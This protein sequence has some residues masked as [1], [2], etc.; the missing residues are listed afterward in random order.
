MRSLKHQ[1]RSDVPQRPLQPLYASAAGS[2]G[3]SSALAAAAAAAV[4]SAPTPLAGPYSSRFTSH[5][6]REMEAQMDQHIAHAEAELEEWMQQQQTTTAI[7]D[8]S[9]TSSLPF[10]LQLT[11]ADGSSVEAAAAA[12]DAS[13]DGGLSASPSASSLLDG[14]VSIP[15][16]VHVQPA[17]Q[18]PLG[19]LLIVPNSSSHAVSG[20]ALQSSPGPALSPSMPLSPLSPA[21]PPHALRSSGGSRGCKRRA[22]ER[23][24]NATAS[25][26]FG[27]GSQSAPITARSGGGGGIDEDQ[28]GS[29]RLSPLHDG[30]MASISS[31]SISPRPLHIRHSSRFLSKAAQLDLRSEAAM[32][33]TSQQRANKDITGSSNDSP[34]ELSLA[35][36]ASL[37]RGSNDIGEQAGST[38]TT[39]IA[40]EHGPDGLLPR[41]PLVGDEGGSG[42]GQSLLGSAVAR[43]KKL[44]A[45]ILAGETGSDGLQAYRR[46]VAASTRI[47][48]GPHSAVLARAGSA[49][50]NNNNGE[51]DDGVALLV[52][53]SVEQQAEEHQVSLLLQRHREAMARS[54]PLAVQLRLAQLH[55][56]QH[57]GALRPNL[58][59]NMLQQQEEEAKQRH[60]QNARQRGSQSARDSTATLLQVPLHGGLSSSRGSSLRSLCS[61]PSGGSLHL[62]LS[63]S[64]SAR[65]LLLPRKKKMTFLTQSL[66]DSSLALSDASYV[67]NSSRGAGLAH[68]RARVMA[69]VNDPDAIGAAGGARRKGLGAVSFDYSDRFADRDLRAEMEGGLAN[70]SLAYVLPV[71]NTMTHQAA[72]AARNTRGA[73]RGPKQPVAPALER[74]LA[75]MHAMNFGAPAPMDPV[76]SF[77]AATAPARS[78]NGEGM[79]V[80]GLVTGRDVHASSAATP[81]QQRTAAHVGPGS[82]ID[83]AHDGRTMAAK[84]HARLRAQGTSDAIAAGGGRGRM[85]GG[86][87][88]SLGMSSTDIGG[89]IGGDPDVVGNA[90]GMDA[91]YAARLS[92]RNKLT[93]ELARFDSATRLARSL[94]RAGE[95]AP[96]V[97][98]YVPKFGLTEPRGGKGGA[99][100]MHP[101]SV[102]P[103][104]A[105]ENE[106][107]G[108]DTPGVGSYDVAH[109]GSIGAG[110]GG[111]RAEHLGTAAG[112]AAAGKASN[113][114]GFGSS[115]SRAVVALSASAL[116]AGGLLHRAAPTTTRE[117]RLVDFKQMPR[118]TKRDKALIAAD[119]A[120]LRKPTL[121]AATTVIAPVAETESGI[122]S[123]LDNVPGFNSPGSSTNSPQQ[124][125]QVPLAP[126]PQS[127]QALLLPRSRWDEML[128]AEL[129]AER[130]AAAQ[131]HH[132][133]SSSTALPMTRRARPAI[134]PVLLMPAEVMASKD[135]AVK[136]DWLRA[137]ARSN[138]F[139]QRQ[140][141]ERHQAQLAE[142]RARFLLLQSREA[143]IAARD[144]LR[145]VQQ[146][147]LVLMVHGMFFA[148]YRAR[149]AADNRRLL[150]L[151]A[152]LTLQYYWRLRNARMLASARYQ[153]LLNK[154]RKS[155]LFFVV[156]VFINNENAS[157]LASNLLLT[158]VV[159]IP[160]VFRF[161]ALLSAACQSF[162]HPSQA[163]CPVAGVSFPPGP[164]ECGRSSRRA[165]VAQLSPALQGLCA[166]GATV[167]TDLFETHARRSGSSLRA[168][169]THRSARERIVGLP[170]RR[171]PSSAVSPTIR[172]RLR[173]SS[174][175][176]GS[177]KARRRPGCRSILCP[178]DNS[179]RICRCC[180]R[181]CGHGTPFAQEGRVATTAGWRQQ[182]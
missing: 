126:A 1:R 173:A 27:G 164:L 49:K 79:D 72:L 21:P 31:S 137:R 120:R 43:K 103:F 105:Q 19:P 169:G 168:T 100:K 98:S 89:A 145:L 146:R 12:A 44:L 70:E 180:C 64:N 133:P 85:Q 54:V 62:S 135:P 97:G 56:E 38:T 138:N 41:L 134:E 32:L 177:R 25:L 82:Y 60:R 181:C 65:G 132:G 102:K 87:T 149:H 175:A 117:E 101:P 91:E 127:Q 17:G 161:H 122:L 30:T 23:N 42:S 154:L 59:E 111:P 179:D 157:T 128:H 35:F 77:A 160:R 29:V 78:A 8:S 129:A 36:A 84:V 20:R 18:S 28:V 136:L 104:A 143:K 107:G 94:A 9:S 92:A 50:E 178:H 182:Q 40:E 22:R 109:V 88:P 52:A 67:S 106:G 47:T 141:L 165:Q 76:S 81:L 58:L 48:G 96:P 45:A 80:L 131:Q 118:I 119:E 123:L 24:S 75:K 124:P 110:A 116:A 63:N 147:W 71:R 53:D 114:V 16:H 7:H 166:H 151:Q 176:G 171:A 158:P 144:A 113:F 6:L 90:A 55:Y 15:G 153:R 13:Y 10:Q 130:R 26:S 140:A 37:M 163:S 115:S 73:Y 57:E 125:Q 121:A 139:R 66:S 172:T 152:A 155:F 69:S 142:K 5:P 3:P 99:V 170:G 108:S 83:E 112:L 61:S 174:T 4:A 95:A 33:L 162:S 167:C 68:H 150:I 46:R 148:R 156:S 2:V 14:S 11:A 74:S 86:G 34:S 51:D 39:T 159:C 93:V